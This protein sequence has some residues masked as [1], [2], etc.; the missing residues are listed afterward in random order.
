MSTYLASSE[1]FVSPACAIYFPFPSNGSDLFVYRPGRKHPLVLISLTSSQD[2]VIELRLPG[3]MHANQ[4]LTSAIFLLRTYASG[5]RGRHPREYCSR[6][7]ASSSFPRSPL[8]GTCVVVLWTSI[9]QHHAMI[10]LSSGKSNSSPVARLMT[11]R[12]VRRLRHSCKACEGISR[13]SMCSADAGQLRQFSLDL[14]HAETMMKKGRTCTYV[15]MYSPC[16]VQLGFPATN[17]RIEY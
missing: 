2:L 1:V 17:Q 16:D 6:I 13:D 14:I 3:Q 10:P 5:H 8:G 11:S 15:S 9:V 4:V 7:P 12:N